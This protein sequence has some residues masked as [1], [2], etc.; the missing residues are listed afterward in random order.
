[1]FA[2][3]LLFLASLVVGGYLYWQNQDQ[4]D[5]KIY[6]TYRLEVDT[7]SFPTIGTVP[8]ANAEGGVISSLSVPTKPYCPSGTSYNRST[9]K[10]EGSP[11]PSGSYYNSSTGECETA[12]CPTGYSYNPSRRVCS[13]FACQPWEYRGWYYGS[14]DPSTGKCGEDA[15]PFDSYYDPSTGKC[16]SGMW[17]CRFPD[18]HYDLIIDLCVDNNGFWDY[19]WGCSDP[20]TDPSCFCR[21]GYVK[22]NYY[23]Y[24][25][26]VGPP[27][28]CP[29]T[30]PYI[31][32][33]LVFNPSNGK[34]EY[35][36]IDPCPD[37]S[38]DPSTGL[39][40]APPLQGCPSGFS[41]NPSTGVC[42]APSQGCPSGTTLN[43]ST[44]K[45]EGQAI[46][47]GGIKVQMQQ[48]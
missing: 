18:E 23:N 7:T 41:F 13:N 11:C 32:I 9:G 16:W 27:A 35:V 43:P 42:E 36:N 3:F 12:L 20:T 10:C 26:C 38:L 4:I 14:Y 44:G 24:Y 47:M 45:C 33:I 19:I 46:T 37:G 6:D 25:Y 22:T 39:C 15:C 34:C 30:Y 2:V 31:D 8:M 17:K 29:S 5:T 1:M 28:P 40:Y 48:Q 21:W